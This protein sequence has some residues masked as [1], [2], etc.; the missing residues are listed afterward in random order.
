MINQTTLF[1]KG[2]VNKMKNSKIEI[3]TEAEI[4]KEVKRILGRSGRKGIETKAIKEYKE[5]LSFLKENKNDIDYEEN[6]RLAKERF[7]K[8]DDL[9]KMFDMRKTSNKQRLEAI[10][11]TMAST[12]EIDID[13]KNISNQDV[14]NYIENIQDL[15]DN[16]NTLQNIAS[17]QVGEIYLMA[18][19]KGY[20]TNEL[21]GLVQGVQATTNTYDVFLST[22]KDLLS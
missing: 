9:S 13:I 3:M 6:L 19:E 11:K 10:K 21:I 16:I 12:S 5:A 15:T 17:E 1:F 8:N 2:G 14:I 20:T 4:N 18:R 22:I 7:L